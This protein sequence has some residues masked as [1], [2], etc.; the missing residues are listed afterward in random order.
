MFLNKKY[1][2]MRL[3]QNKV[4]TSTIYK[5]EHLHFYS[6]LCSYTSPNLRSV[7]VSPSSIKF[8][9]LRYVG[10]DSVSSF[11]FFN[12][13]FEVLHISEYEKQYL[14]LPQQNTIKIK[15]HN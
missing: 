1:F 13:D 7:T 12:L 9:V 3:K 11:S 14:L 6:S 8:K 4:N 10:S 5:P 15:L 2:S